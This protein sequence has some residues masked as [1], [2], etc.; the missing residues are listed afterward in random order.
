MRVQL[1]HRLT[2]AVLP[3]AAT[4]IASSWVAASIGQKLGHGVLDLVVTLN[5]A[6]ETAALPPA[7]CANLGSECDSEAIEYWSPGEGSLLADSGRKIPASRRIGPTPRSLYVDAATVLCLVQ[8]G[9][10]PDGK[11]VPAKGSRPVGLSLYGVSRLG[12]GVIDGDIL[13]DVLGQPV[14]SAAL[15]VAMV[16][17]ARAVNRS[18]IYG[19]LW[20]GMRP[21]SIAVEQP[22]G[23]PNCSPDEHDCWRSRCGTGKMLPLATQ[24]ASVSAAPKNNQQKNRR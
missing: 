24:P 8:N 19:T 12:I 17:A 13:T 3:F 2:L 14:H 4:T 22:Y 21:Y 16:V 23:T 10:Q 18:I 9:V 7:P 11:P 1:W 6:S 20:R 5:S 15:V